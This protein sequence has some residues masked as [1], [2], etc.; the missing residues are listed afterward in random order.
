MVLSPLKPI[1]VLSRFYVNFSVIVNN[2]RN[3]VTRFFPLKVDHSVRF[4][5]VAKSSPVKIQ[6]KLGQV[7][8]RGTV[9]KTNFVCGYGCGQKSADV[10]H[11]ICIVL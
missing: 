6:A 9:H 4:D 5:L 10:I 1:L 2:L 11:Y 8:W 3:I 7:K